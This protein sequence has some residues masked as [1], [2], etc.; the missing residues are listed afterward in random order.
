MTI[1]PRRIFI[2]FSHD[3]LLSDFYRQLH[4]ADK[5]PTT[6]Y[7]ESERLPD[8]AIDCVSEKTYPLAT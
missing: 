3:D 6:R 8:P 2:M 1:S 4:G 5:L 7:G